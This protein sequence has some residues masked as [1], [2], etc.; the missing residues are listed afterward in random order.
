[1]LES[2]F[3]S[4]GSDTALLVMLATALRLAAGMNLLL[5]NYSNSS[6]MDL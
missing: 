6:A 1:M 3:D 4:T 5:P 2:A